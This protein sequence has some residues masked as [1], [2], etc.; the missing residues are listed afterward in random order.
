[1][2]VSIIIPVCADSQAIAEAIAGLRAQTLTSWEAIVVDGG[3]SPEIAAV[4]ARSAG[5]DP[6]IRVVR[7][8]G[9]GLNEA[10]NSGAKLARFKW[11]LFFDPEHKLLPELLARLTHVAAA[12]R[13]DAVSSQWAYVAPDGA[14]LAEEFWGAP[15]DM[16]ATF[17]S[18]PAFPLHA[19]IVRTSVFEAVGGFDTRRST[20]ADWDLWQRIARI[21]ARF[22]SVDEA[23]ALIA[24]QASQDSTDLRQL[25]AD[26]LRL[27]AL[28]QAPDA[29]VAHLL[30]AHANGLPREQAPNAR[31]IFACMVAGLALGPGHLLVKVLGHAVD[32]DQRAGGVG[33]G[34]R[35]AGGVRS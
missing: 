19:C 15:G 11:L 10:R 14:L 32:L 20:C 1:M 5:Q 17:A 30:P 9:I 4:I 18:H 16:F 27:I 6:R 23:L 2:N 8:P 28:G 13:F 22:G 26:G 12:P 34:A 25:L 21:G 35:I 33:A 7:R 29:R 3:V 24:M 31:F